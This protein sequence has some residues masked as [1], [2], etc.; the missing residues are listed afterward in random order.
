MSKGPFQQVGNAL[1]YITCS[2]A[3]IT[4]VFLA[5]KSGGHQIIEKEHGKMKQ[6]RSHKDSLFSILLTCGKLAFMH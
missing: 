5:V 3:I 2:P 6:K 4:L 1:G